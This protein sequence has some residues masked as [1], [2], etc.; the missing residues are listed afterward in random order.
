MKT[1]I[2]APNGA[3]PLKEVLSAPTTKQIIA[4]LRADPRTTGRKLRIFLSFYQTF[5]MVAQLQDQGHD[6]ATLDVEE[7]ATASS[8]LIEANFDTIMQTFSSE[9]RVLL[10]SLFQEGGVSYV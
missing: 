3:F 1:F 7:I 2:A 6:T 5:D 8:F 9:E 10:N 4:S